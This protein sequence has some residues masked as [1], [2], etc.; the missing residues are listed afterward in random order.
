MNSEVTDSLRAVPLSEAKSLLAEQRESDLSVA[1]FARAK[2]VKPWSLYNARASE[3][4]RTRKS[5]E[6]RFA[7]VDVVDPPPRAADPSSSIELV[8][9]SGIALRV[10]RDFDE[11]ALRRLLGVLGSC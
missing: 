10:R 1:A 6:R 4:R 5:T 8:L 9:P 7:Q 2:G 11:V 3:Q